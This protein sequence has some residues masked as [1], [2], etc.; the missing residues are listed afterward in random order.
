MYIK[1]LMDEDTL[2][3]KNVSMY[4]GCQSCSSV[5]G[6]LT[7]YPDIEISAEN[8]A[9]RYINNN[10]SSAVVFGGSESFDFIDDIISFIDLIRNKY[11]NDD[12]II[13]YSD[14][15]EDEIKI[16][17]KNYYK[18][19]KEYSNIIIKFGR[20]MPGQDSHMDNILGIRLRS[21]NQYAKK[22]S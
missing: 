14:Y 9:E 16:K 3:Y 2:Y 22:I 4:V 17:Y 11:H 20:F 10:N 15:S 7:D 12:N 18:A 13:I 21:N 8:L 6:T 5:F 1:N 19:L